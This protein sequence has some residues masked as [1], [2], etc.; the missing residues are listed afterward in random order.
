MPIRISEIGAP[1]EVRIPSTWGSDGAKSCDFEIFVTRQKKFSFGFSEETKFDSE[2]RNSNRKKISFSI[3]FSFFTKCPPIDNAEIGQLHRTS[4]SFYFNGS[5]IDYRASSLVE[6]VRF[7]LIMLHR[8]ISRIAKELNTKYSDKEWCAFEL[9]WKEEAI[10]EAIDVCEVIYSRVIFCCSV[11][12]GSWCSFGIFQSQGSLFCVSSIGREKIA[13]QKSKLSPKK[14]ILSFGFNNTVLFDQKCFHAVMYVPS[15][16][17]PGENS[18]LWY[19]EWVVVKSS[20]SWENHRYWSTTY[21]ADLCQSWK[22]NLIYPWL[23][24]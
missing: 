12:H 2:I 14:K 23:W 10:Y 8:A 7:A 5:I 15:F 13:L 22:K 6:W 9:G 20:P 11:I 17:Q 24:S 18:I 16:R 21:F 4:F 1:F 3:L 19:F